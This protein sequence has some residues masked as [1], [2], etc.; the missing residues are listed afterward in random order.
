MSDVTVLDGC[1][2]FTAEYDSYMIA[3]SFA[4]D[5]NEY[6]KFKIRI[7]ADYSNTADPKN[8]TFE[9][10]FLTDAISSFSD[11]YR[12]TFNVADYTNSAKTLTVTGT[13]A[14]EAGSTVVNASIEVT[15]KPV[16]KLVTDPKE[17]RIYQYGRI[18]K[19]R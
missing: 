2:S 15:E 11:S 19:R 12:H 14:N 17:L 16:L 4:L 7:K 8:N 9:L 10:Y 6:A 18:S 5:A 13:L 1:L 3:Q